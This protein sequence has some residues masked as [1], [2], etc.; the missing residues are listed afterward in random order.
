MKKYK[1]FENRPELS[2]TEI[3]KG[4]DFSKIKSKAGISPKSSL[5]KMIVAGG[6][7]VAA[8]IITTAVLL[9][10]KSREDEPLT[11]NELPAILTNNENPAKQFRID[12]S[13]DTTIIFESGSIIK[14][15]ARCFTDSAGHPVTGAIDLDYREFHNVAEIMLAGIPMR[16]DSAGKESHFESAGMFEIKGWQHGKNIHIAKDKSIEVAMISLNPDPS[17]FNQY[18]LE[19]NKWVFTGKDKPDY[20]KVVDPAKADT[21]PAKSLK[22]LAQKFVKPIL[23]NKKRQQF[24]IDVNPETYPELGVFRK[25]IFE[26]SPKMKDFDPAKANQAWYDAEVERTKTQ[27]EYKITFKG[28]I[29]GK[30]EE[31]EVVGYPVVDETEYEAAIKKYNSLSEAYEQK[32]NK[33]IQTENAEESKLNSQLDRYV[34]AMNRYR[35]LAKENYQLQQQSAES[36]QLVYRTFQIQRFGIFNSDCPQS[37]PQGMILAAEFQ[38]EKGQH[39]EAATIYLVEKGVNA[40]YTFYPNK[41]VYYTPGADNVMFVITKDNTLGWITRDVLDQVNRSAKKATFKMNTV[42]KPSYS[43]SDI[44]KLIS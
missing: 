30:P 21:V 23:R 16:Y 31:Y 27:G 1:I 11:Q 14:I 42:R 13:K 37:M 4:M 34:D 9:M 39:M 40:L 17:K 3:E 35:K 19:N 26:V 5:A 20:I 44:T 36:Q 18:Y 38:D 12:N 33:K 7:G 28:M 32:M 29:Q 41:N 8:V 6:I 22:N 25:V 15:P 10:T 24:M 2:Q 43:L